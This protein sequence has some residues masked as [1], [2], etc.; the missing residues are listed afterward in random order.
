MYTINLENEWLETNALGSYC[1]DTAASCHTRKYHGLFIYDDIKNNEK[2]VLLSGIDDKVFIDNRVYDLSSRQYENCD[3]KSN[4]LKSFSDETHPHFT[5]DCDGINIEKEIL[6]LH[7]KNILLVRYTVK[8]ASDKFINVRLRPLFAYRNIHRL[9][10]ENYAIN[11]N[12]YD[13]GFYK[14]IMPYEGMPH[15]YCMTYS[16]ITSANAFYWYKNFKYE[17][18]KERGFDYLEDLFSPFEYHTRLCD[19]II[20]AFSTDKIE[21]NTKDLRVL[22]DNE[23]TRREHLRSKGNDSPLLTTSQS[24][25]KFNKTSHKAESVI[26]GFPWF[27]NWGRDTMISLPGLCLYSE[28][29][30]GQK[31]F[32]NI[33]RFYGNQIKN[34][35]IPNILGRPQNAYNSADGSLWFIWALQEYY[36][37][38]EKTDLIEELTPSLIDIVNSYL[39]GTLYNI[40][41]KN[42]LL[43]AGNKD[44]NVTWMDAV[45]EN[46]PITSRFGAAVELNALWYNDLVFLSKILKSKNKPLAKKLK[47]EAKLTRKAILEN[48]WIKEKN[49][50][51]DFFN[52]EEK[53]AQIR[54]NQLLAISLKFSAFSHWKTKKIFKTIWAN[55][56]TDFGLRTLAPSDEN[57]IGHYEGDAKKRDRAYHNGT[58]W[59]WLIGNLAASYVKI[60][61]Q[62]KARKELRPIITNLTLSLNSYGINSICEIM[63]GD[64]PH[65]QN[66]CISQAW[67]VAELI[68]AKNIIG[69]K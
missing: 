29:H 2:Y 23:I 52:D 28:S 39:N 37:K 69:D 3:E 55:L 34:G 19:E 57:Y 11:K 7:L 54:P 40:H 14:E 30:D 68:R 5:Y 51:Y 61:G 66:G 33:M 13:N 46:K 10:H 44:T 1:S 8:N 21:F 24:F 42:H 59:P 31:N 41:V 25:L 15:F 64:E 63:D 6:F 32:A 43:Y 26:A 20:I 47:Q 53:N 62:K 65:K 9:T 12:V 50:L 27:G 60:F 35:L 36:L 48:F 45:A 22:W 17:R 49:Y 4:S 67:S 38:T 58:I 16:D 56:K 18:E